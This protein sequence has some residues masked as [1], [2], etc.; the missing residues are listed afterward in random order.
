MSEVIIKTKTEAAEERRQKYEAEL[1]ERR[2]ANIKRNEDAKAE[3]MAKV[4]M[5]NVHK[6][7]K[8]G[9]NVEKLDVI[10]GKFINQLIDENRGRGLLEVDYSGTSKEMINRRRDQMAIIRDHINLIKQLKDVRALLSEEAEGESKQNLMSSENVILIDEARELLA[11]K[12]LS[13]DV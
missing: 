6:A 8:N 12:G 4:G 13:I 7:L 5:M 11:K 10:I 9:S 3:K 2:L 1:E